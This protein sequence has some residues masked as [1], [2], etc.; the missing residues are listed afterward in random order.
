WSA[1][2]LGLAPGASLTFTI[3]GALGL[4][5]APSTVSDTAFVAGGIACSRLTAQSNAVGAALAPHLTSVVLRQTQTPPDGTALVPGSPVTYRID[6]T[7]TGTATITRLVVDDTVPALIAWSAVTA[8][9][10]AFAAPT[11]TPVGGPPSASRY[12]WSASSLAFAPG[13][14]YTFTVT[15]QVGTV[16]GGGGGS[17]TA[18]AAATGPCSTTVLTTPGAGFTVTGP[19]A[20]LAVALGVSPAT[21][22]APG[23]ITFTIVV[24]NTG[25]DTITA[26]AISDTLPAQ[27]A[28]D[29]VQSNTAGLAFAQ[30]GAV[31]SWTG[32]LAL[33][34]GGTV[35]AVVEATAACGGGPALDVA[36]AAASAGCGGAEASTPGVACAAYTP[37]VGASASLVQL[38]VAPGIG[39]PVTY[40]IVVTNTGGATLTS[41]T[42]VDTVAAA[43]WGQ[44]EEHPA[45]FAAPV[46]T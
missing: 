34:P 44:A 32:P 27:V 46:I 13:Q 29:G 11:V 9:P 2:G 22:V 21:P 36:Y 25:A 1:T 38:P 39:E 4:V 5:C 3:T 31:V 14:T 37:A 41:V 24:T 42:V 28:Y 7:N 45:A 8:Q 6:V 16:C 33:A 26:L 40:R 18:W 35:T 30:A 19:T 17:A 15:G 12:E 10:A 43:V 23:A 20:S